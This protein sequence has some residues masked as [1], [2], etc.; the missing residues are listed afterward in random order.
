MKGVF[1]KPRKVVVTIEMETDEPI[2]DIKQDIFEGLDGF[3]F[4]IKQVQVNVIKKEK[5][6]FGCKLA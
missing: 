3:G 6:T 2:K 4:E 5:D 1:M